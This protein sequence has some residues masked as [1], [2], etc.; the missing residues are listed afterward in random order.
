ML[1]SKCLEKLNGANA[2]SFSEQY[3]RLANAAAEA[4]AAT[5]ELVISWHDSDTTSEDGEFVP[6]L[7]IR[8]RSLESMPE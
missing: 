3:Q 4:N 6:E 2:K 8:V 1:N 5:A 7:V